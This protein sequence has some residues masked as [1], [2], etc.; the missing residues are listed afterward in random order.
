M[1]GPFQFVTG[2]HKRYTF[3]YPKLCISIL[4]KHPKGERRPHP[5]GL[6]RVDVIYVQY[7]SLYY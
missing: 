2:V 4:V 1:A 5:K 3:I 6:G 7:G